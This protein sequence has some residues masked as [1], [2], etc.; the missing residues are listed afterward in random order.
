M[1]PT[2]SRA[3]GRPLALARWPW[4][5]DEGP[6]PLAPRRTPQRGGVLTE[7][8]FDSE[9]DALGRKEGD[10]LRLGLAVVSAAAHGLGHVLGLLGVHGSTRG[11]RGHRG[12]CGFDGR[13]TRL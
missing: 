6:Q 12:R 10:G 13:S 7:S 11:A 5:G 9:R 8:A 1:D 3:T 4:G 2:G